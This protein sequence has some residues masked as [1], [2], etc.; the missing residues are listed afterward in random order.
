MTFPDRRSANRTAPRSIPRRRYLARGC[1]LRWIFRVMDRGGG[2]WRAGNFPISAS[3]PRE[4]PLLN[5]FRDFFTCPPPAVR[6]P[7]YE[8]N[9]PG[10]PFYFPHTTRQLSSTPP[11]TV[12]ASP[13]PSN[14]Q[15]MSEKGKCKRPHDG[16]PPRKARNRE[17]GNRETFRQDLKRAVREK[18]KFTRVL[19]AKAGACAA[20]RTWISSYLADY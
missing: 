20:L 4:T 11:S 13:P 9:H 7:S 6:R 8:G 16:P 15:E 12:P 2:A 1:F 5:F 17:Q 18:K 19:G 3:P 10:T 14:T